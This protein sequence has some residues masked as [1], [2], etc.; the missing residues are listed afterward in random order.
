MDR[1]EVI[2]MV[3]CRHCHGDQQIHVLAPHT[4]QCETTSILPRETN[5]STTAMV[6]KVP[7][8]FELR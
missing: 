4:N 5:Y 3:S 7:F 2:E 6:L 8:F 1:L